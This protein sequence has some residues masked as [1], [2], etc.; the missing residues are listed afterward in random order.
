MD[1]DPEKWPKVCN[2]RQNGGGHRQIAQPFRQ[3]PHPPADTIL[4]S[5]LTSIRT[6]SC[7]QL[8]GK[9]QNKRNIFCIFKNAGNL[10]LCF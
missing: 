5:L 4:D 9:I 7:K 6:L 1:T 8:L 2:S 3:A 10:H